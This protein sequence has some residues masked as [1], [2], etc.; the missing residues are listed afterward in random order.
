MDVKFISRIFFIKAGNYILSVV[1]VI[2]FCM[3]M[4]IQRC[5]CEHTES[6]QDYRGSRSVVMNFLEAVEK[7]ALRSKI[8]LTPVQFL[9]VE[10]LF[11]R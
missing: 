11:V 3:Q 10:I 1:F 2:F 5:R 8:R 9:A 4:I 7:R 6:T